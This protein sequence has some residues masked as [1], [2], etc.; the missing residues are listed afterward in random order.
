MS[1]SFYDSVENLSS[2]MPISIT[3]WNSG[4]I[5][6]M[7][8]NAFP[9]STQIEP[10]DRGAALLIAA[11]ALIAL[12]GVLAALLVKPILDHFDGR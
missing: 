3:R 1:S 10:V 12:A 5:P 6:E 9:L 11:A 7:S 8:D 4:H 2:V